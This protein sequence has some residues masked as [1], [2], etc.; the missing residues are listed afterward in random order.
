MAEPGSICVSGKVHDEVNRKLDLGFENLGEREVKNIAT[1]VRV[2]RAF[3]WRPY[4]STVLSST[5][6][7]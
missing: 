6:G 5:S 4:S 1:P 3:S 2:Y 7:V